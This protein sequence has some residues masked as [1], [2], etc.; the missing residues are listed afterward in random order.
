MSATTFGWLVLL[1][2][3]LGTVTLAFGFRRLPGRTA[4]WIGTGAIALAFV[5]AVGALIALQGEAPAHRE[6]TSSL[7]NY[8]V[9]AGIDAHVSILVDPLSVYMIL[10]VAG[11]STL[12]HL[13]SVSYLEEDRGFARYF[14]YLNFFVFR[15]SC[16]SSPAT[17]CC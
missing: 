15:C 13:Y 9:T 8:A 11:I 14:S 4:G 16:S 12:I 10:V 7:W 17:S 5:A 2:P 3:L 1:F 6:L